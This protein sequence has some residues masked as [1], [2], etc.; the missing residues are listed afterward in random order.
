[1]S[2]GRNFDIRERFRLQI[3]AEFTNIFNRTEANNPTAS[4]AFATQT[5]AA[6][7]N[8]SG[9][10]GSIITNPSTGAVTFAAPRQGMVVARFQF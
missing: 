6:N 5:H 10:F 2:L 1:M 7:G 8:T 9:G 3:R 4:N